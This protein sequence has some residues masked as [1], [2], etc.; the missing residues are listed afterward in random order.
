MVSGRTVFACH[1]LYIGH[2]TDNDLF[3]VSCL[4]DSCVPLSVM[5]TSECQ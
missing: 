4:Q 2:E 1:A 5:C 3:V